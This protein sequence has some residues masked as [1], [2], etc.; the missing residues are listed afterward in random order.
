MSV[1]QPDALPD[2]LV[3]LRIPD[4]TQLPETDGTFV[5]NFQEHPQSLLLTESLWPV[6]QQHHP[7]GQ[8]CIGQDSGIYWH[9]EAANS[10]TPVRGAIAPDWFYVPGVPPL[11]NGQIRRSYVMWKELVAP[12]LV[13][14][15]VSGDGSEERDQ[16][17]VT[18]K[19]WI[20]E[21][22]IRPA[23][24]GIYNVRQATIDVYHLTDGRYELIVANEREH[25]PVAPLGIELGIWQG[26]YHGMSLPWLRC[27]D[28]A[29]NLLLTGAERA[30]QEHQRAERLAARLRALGIDPDDTEAQ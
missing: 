15:F 7:D 3:G 26:T 22:F 14:E 4:H 20:Y 11:L 16:T 30:E 10:D 5:H 19:F 17:P 29:G 28:A 13:F 18:G 25:Y 6:L 8:F 21:Q 12:F 27:W 9:L 24:Y 1:S 2:F 23:F